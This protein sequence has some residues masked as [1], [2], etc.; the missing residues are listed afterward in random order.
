[1]LRT[2]AFLAFLAFMLGFS[3][4]KTDSNLFMSQ[5][6]AAEHG[7]GG[8]EGGK[9]EAH[10]PDFE[11]IQLDPILLPVI[12]SKGLTQQVNLM[13]KLEVPYG[14][15]DEVEPFVPRLVDAY[16]QDLYGSLSSGHGMIKDGFINVV[17]V[18]KRL[19]DVTKKIMGEK[20]EEV[21]GVLLQVLQQRPL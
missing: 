2:I 3:P 16:L 12:T 13:V 9:D 11:Y 7:G 10:H 8:G 5:A 4:L 17:E 20:H 14:K 6:F 21:S 18:K 15:K 19:L 1:M